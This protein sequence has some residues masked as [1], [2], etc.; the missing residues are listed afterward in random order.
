[1]VVA[2]MEGSKLAAASPG[3]QLAVA[4]AES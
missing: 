3:P 1:V 2:R 4:I